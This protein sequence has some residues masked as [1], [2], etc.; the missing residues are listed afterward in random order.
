MRRLALLCAFAALALTACRDT[1]SQIPLVAVD[2][3]INI[4]EPQYFDLNVATGWVYITGGSRG[5]VIYRNSFDEFTAMDRHVP[6]NVQNGCAVTVA[7][8]NVLL[9]DPCSE[10][11]W[12][13]IDGTLVTG[14]AQASLKTYRTS[15]ANPFL[16]IYN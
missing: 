8:D 4:N 14:P 6:Y 1:G 12:L 2:F 3:T 11:Q 15:W 7:D 10:S 9:D 13:I 5:I 16:R